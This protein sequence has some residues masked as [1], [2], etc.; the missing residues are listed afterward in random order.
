LAGCD[1]LRIGWPRKKNPDEKAQQG[2]QS[3][4]GA[5]WMTHISSLTAIHV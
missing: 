4:S 5:Q 2:C 1:Y 3:Q